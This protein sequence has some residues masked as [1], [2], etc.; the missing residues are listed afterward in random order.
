MWVVASMLDSTGIWDRHWI[1]S[2]LQ[3]RKQMWGDP[4]VWK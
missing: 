1:I 2:I 4:T 3:V